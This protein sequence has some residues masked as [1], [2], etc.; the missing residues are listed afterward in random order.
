MAENEMKEEEI[1]TEVTEN[2]TEENLDDITYEQ[3]LAWKKEAD[4]LRSAK[5]KAEA[6]IVELKKGSKNSEPSSPNEAY[7]KEDALIDKF[8]SKHPELEGYEDDL[9]GYLSKGIALDEAKVLVENKDKSIKAKREAE[10]AS[11]LQSEGAPR[12]VKAYTYAELDALPQN[13][14][15]IAMGMIEK[16]QATL[17]K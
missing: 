1:V 10:K 2:V 5:A 13:E 6:K 11:I 14:Y 4:E 16:W 9:K 17:K 8:V 12:G 3:A 7:T 15:N